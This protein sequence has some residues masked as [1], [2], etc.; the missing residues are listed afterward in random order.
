VVIAQRCNV[1]F[2]KTLIL[3]DNMYSTIACMEKPI[4]IKLWFENFKGIDNFEAI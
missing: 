1:A 4:Y 3:R 2:Q